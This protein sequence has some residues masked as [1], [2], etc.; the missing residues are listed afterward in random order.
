MLRF[1]SLGKALPGVV[2]CGGLG[3]GSARQSWRVLI[4]HVRESCVEVRQGKA[5]KSGR[6]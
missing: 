2:R 6:C 4:R 1:G 5:V 3:Q